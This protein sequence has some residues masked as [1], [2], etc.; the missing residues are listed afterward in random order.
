M[1]CIQRGLATRQLSVHPSVCVSVERVDCN[2]TEESFAKIFMPHERLFCLMSNILTIS[3][4]NSKTVRDRMSDFI[5]SK[6]VPILWF[7]YQLNC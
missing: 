2:K 5:L 3:C 7:L 1:H 6:L 4:D